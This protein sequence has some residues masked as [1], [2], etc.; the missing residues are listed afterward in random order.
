MKRVAQ[1]GVIHRPLT[2]SARLAS[3]GLVCCCERRDRLEG[4][5]YNRSR[6][7]SIEV[8]AICE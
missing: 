1:R 2:G 6:L 4:A 5:V 8:V 3:P 7:Y